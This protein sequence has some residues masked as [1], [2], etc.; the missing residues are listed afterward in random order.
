M[1]RSNTYP[2]GPHIVGFL[3]HLL[4]TRYSG[5]NGVVF[6]SLSL[7]TDRSCSFQLRG[8]Y[9]K[10]GMLLVFD[11]SFSETQALLWLLMPLH[12]AGLSIFCWW[13]LHLM[14]HWG[15]FIWIVKIAPIFRGSKASH[16]Q[17][18]IEIACNNEY[19]WFGCNAVA[20]SK[21]HEREITCLYRCFSLKCY[22]KFSF[23]SIGIFTKVAVF[24]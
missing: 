19:L 23:I 1:H 12:H 5:L 4:A 8:G 11:C 13:S 9:E 17:S 2:F 3:L 22:S 20:P 24:L 10:L 21:R 14:S 6:G 18:F 7:R 15:T 16:N